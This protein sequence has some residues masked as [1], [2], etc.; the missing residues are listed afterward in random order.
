MLVSLKQKW[1]E[2]DKNFNPRIKNTVQNSAGQG[3]TLIGILTSWL[4]SVAD[5]RDGVLQKFQVKFSLS[6][7]P[8]VK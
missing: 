8:K 6:W 1:F 5:V 2:I 3:P 4:E 7:N